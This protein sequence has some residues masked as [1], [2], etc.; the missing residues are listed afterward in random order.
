[1]SPGRASG[2]VTASMRMSSPESRMA[3]RSSMPEV[4]PSTSSTPGRE[5]SWG[6]GC[7]DD[8]GTGSSGAPTSAR[9]MAGPMPSSP[10]IGLPTY[11]TV[12]R[13]CASPPRLWRACE[14][15]PRACESEPQDCR[16]EASESSAITKY[17]PGPPGGR[18][19][20]PSWCHRPW[21]SGHRAARLPRRGRRGRR[22]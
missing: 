22:G 5:N 6:S 20:A 13:F 17:R 8:R 12:T 4:P 14:S 21:S 19:R 1:M 18:R 2:T 15:E 11:S 7:A 16:S 9:A 10:M 3:G